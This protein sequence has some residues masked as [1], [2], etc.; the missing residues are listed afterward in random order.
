MTCTH[1]GE[2]NPVAE[3]PCR[4]CGKPLAAEATLGAS[5]ATGRHV[6][7]GNAAETV[8]STASGRG[9][10]GAT[11]RPG[12]RLGERYEILS[13]LGEGGFGAVYKARDSVL[14]RTVAL[15]LIHPTL[16]ANPEVM[17]R[18]KREI[19]LASRI[20]HKNVIRIHDL[21]EV[22][23]LK[24][25]SMNFVEGRDLKEL[26]RRDGP[27]PLETALGLMRQI[28]AALVAAHEAGVV[29]RDLKPQN[30]LVDD[31]GQ[32]Y[33]VDF[34]IS[35]SVDHGKTMTEAGAVMGTV[36]YMSPE[37]ARGDVVDHRTD[38]YSFGLI[39][40]EML[41]GRLP[42]ESA[43]SLSAISVLMRRV[44]EEAPSLDRTRTG[45]PPWITRIVARCLRRDPA[46]RYA[47]VA[48]M[49]ADVE[50][51]TASRARRRWALPRGRTL[52][53][54]GAAAVVAALAL[55]AVLVWRG[56]AS[57]PVPAGPTIG[58]AVVPFRNATGD[59][60]LDW[61]RAGLPNLVRSQLEQ[62]PAL[63]VVAEE[64]VAGIV[65]GLKLDG[66]GGLEPASLLRIAKLTGAERLLAA[67]LYRTGDSYRLEARLLATGAGEIAATDPIR[68]ESS[69]DDALFSMADEL[70]RQVV[71]KLGVRSTGRRKASDLSTASIDALR[72]YT[73]AA[74]RA[75]AGG[76]LEAAERLESALGIDPGFAVARALLAETYA[77]LGRDDDAIRTAEEAARG[78]QEVSQF[79]AARISAVR[80]RLAGDTEAAGAAYRELTRLAPGRPDGQLA[81]GTFLEET[82]DLEGAL[83]ALG[84]AVALDA[85][86][87]SARYAL[88]RVQ[89]KLG[90]LGEAQQELMQ[91]LSLHVESGNEE[92]RATVL[93]GLGNVS[94][95]LGKYD[96]A[97]FYYEESQRVRTEIGDQRGLAVALNNVATILVDL[98]RYDEAIETQR[99]SVAIHQELGDAS[100]LANAYT[101]LGELY[102]RASRPEQALEAY[103]SGLDVVRDSGDEASL[104]RAFSKLGYIYTVLGRY[105]E[106]FFIQKDA[107][108]TRRRLGETNKLIESLVDIGFL[109]HVQGRYDEALSYFAEGLELA[110]RSG[111]QA[112]LVALS[113]NVA[114]IHHE[115]GRYGAALSSARQ[116]VD[117]ARRLGDRNLLLP[118][119]VDLGRALGA[120]GDRSGAESAFAEAGE[121]ARSMGG[122]AS[123][124]ATIL[125]Q[126]GEMLLDHGEPRGA[127]AV[128]TGA[129]SA[130]RASKDVRL[131][132]LA[133]LRDAEAGGGATEIVRVAEESRTRRLK[134]LESDARL[135]LAQVYLAAGRDQPA[136]EQAELAAGE[137]AALGRRDV[138]FQAQHAAAEA[139]RRTGKRSEALL[140]AASA[141][142][143]LEELRQGLPAELL[144]SF[145]ALPRVRAFSRTAEALVAGGGVEG[146]DL[147]ARLQRAL[148]PATR[149]A[150]DSP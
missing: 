118:S 25:I 55:A 57:V 129:L 123:F 110:R 23:P 34:G 114:A 19:L 147:A 46:D 148:A 76:D 96:Q 37:Q 22:G 47:S 8:V 94:R 50:R 48:E 92:G 119:L 149:P 144:D 42:F 56:R 90:N 7:G 4:A 89:A 106:A 74:E 98:G 132:L 31:G 3:G 13:V 26:L 36:A 137:A 84:R 128:L 21:G 95:A 32:A 66:G 33:I 44:Q 103:Q 72:L 141:S 131:E 126:R 93:N 18:F 150:P 58:L 27:L 121:L 91:A 115:Q 122:N 124:E 101:N 40:H 15:K 45:L 41:A 105:N 87:P 133:R 64:R 51:Q 143:R 1:C 53:A 82:G 68:V 99:K 78:L 125:T 30:V 108:A 77:R 59:P 85:S 104:A 130:A 138:L 20:T 127:A 107:L 54:A 6:P 61:T 60:G 109:E 79:E 28:G 52:K 29:H 139:L 88:G 75:R 17:E 113:T 117:G 71:G 65:D 80:A 136:L 24:F 73:E 86:S 63:R 38:I 100:G 9:E 39:V 14:E 135:V 70:S 81:L 62:S 12:E 140:R 11:L 111:H 112:A 102:A 49:L 134:P 43:E 10:S 142:E 2:S 5:A 67:D 69:G 83:V 35:R 116:A 97:L 146:A 145:L 16:A 120:A